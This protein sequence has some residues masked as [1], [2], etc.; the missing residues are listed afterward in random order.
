MNEVGNVLVCY[1]LGHILPT[2][3]ELSATYLIKPLRLKLRG[4]TSNLNI[5]YNG[6]ILYNEMKSLTL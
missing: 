3:F 1:I 6:S 2:T 4:Y 5:L